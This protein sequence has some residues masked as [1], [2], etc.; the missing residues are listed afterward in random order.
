MSETLRQRLHDEVE[1]YNRLTDQLQQAE[2]E[3]QQR[4]G[5][6]SLLQEL[7]G[8]GRSDDRPT[9]VSDENGSVPT[10]S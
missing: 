8:E 4:L 10:V 5:R 1:A 2:Q 7:L 9:T 3:R 6:I